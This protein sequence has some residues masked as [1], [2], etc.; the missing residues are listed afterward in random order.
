[1]PRAVVKVAG[2]ECTWIDMVIVV[3]VVG[4]DSE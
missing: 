1:M 2:V 4:T 3:V